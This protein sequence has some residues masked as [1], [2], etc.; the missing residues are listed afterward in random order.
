[1]H[2]IRTRLRFVEFN[3]KEIPRLAGPEQSKDEDFQPMQTI[4][5]HSFVVPLKGERNVTR[6]DFVISSLGKETK[7]RRDS[8][9]YPEIGSKNNN[10][11]IR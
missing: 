10:N 6:D 7:T 3:G 4:V 5:W 2:R 9:V 11:I 8:T 1:M